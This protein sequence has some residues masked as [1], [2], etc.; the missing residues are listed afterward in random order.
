MRSTR[1][2]RRLNGIKLKGPPLLDRGMP[3]LETTANLER[4]LWREIV[5]SSLP[6]EGLLGNQTAIRMP[7]AG[8]AGEDMGADHAQAGAG[9]VLPVEV[10]AT[11]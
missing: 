10:G 2:L 1:G 9:H 11:R 5:D 3:Q 6:L 8:Y 4:G 7:R